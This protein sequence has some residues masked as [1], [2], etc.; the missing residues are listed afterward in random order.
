MKIKS[1]Q[2]FIL[3]YVKGILLESY[4]ELITISQKQLLQYLRVALMLIRSLL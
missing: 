1:I 2:N 4:S 3:V